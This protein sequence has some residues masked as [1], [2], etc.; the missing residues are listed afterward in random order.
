MGSSEDEMFTGRLVGLEEISEDKLVKI[1]NMFSL[2]D[3]EE[4]DSF[5]D[6]TIFNNGKKGILFTNRGIHWKLIMEKGFIRYCDISDLDYQQ[7]KKNINILINGKKMEIITAEFDKEEISGH[8]NGCI[9]EYNQISSQFPAE[10]LKIKKVTS[11][12][13]GFFSR[14]FIIEIPYILIGLGIAE[15]YNENSLFPSIDYSYL[16]LAGGILLL[17]TLP[18]RIKKGNARKK[19]GK[20]RIISLTMHILL[21]LLLLFWESF[22][23]SLNEASSSTGG[24]SN[25]NTENQISYVKDTFHGGIDFYNHKDKKIGSFSSTGSDFVGHGNTFYVLKSKNTSENRYETYNIRG[26]QIGFHFTTGLFKFIR[27]D[28]DLMIFQEKPGG[29]IENVY[30]DKKFNIKKRIT[31]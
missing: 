7:E 4:I 27:C 3:G 5:I 18:Y 2:A 15:Y 6:D 20:R 21:I 1:K 10:N 17:L 13:V 24:T 29:F 14:I 26:N 8:I 19:I 12:K 30:R 9:E 23:K 16:I 22:K 28:N 31:V 11:P 25:N